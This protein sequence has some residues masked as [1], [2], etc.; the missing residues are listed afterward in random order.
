MKQHKHLT[1]ILA[2]ALAG[3]VLGL[4]IGVFAIPARNSGGQSCE[5]AGEYLYSQLT[6]AHRNLSAYAEE[7]DLDA[8][9]Q[10]AAA[11][12]HAEG[13]CL[14]FGKDFSYL[15][16]SD[17]VQDP[18]WCVAMI[19][20]ASDEVDAMGAELLPMQEKS[21]KQLLAIFAP[22][23]ASG[24]V[25]FSTLFENTAQTDFRQVLYC[26]IQGELEE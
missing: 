18:L 26:P 8:L 5:A 10:A 9:H 4:L 6:A 12:H 15:S 14:G 19:A 22:E 1:G 13:V 7:R 16:K 3:L 24:T 23:E 11:L 17:E 20:Y 2:A 25:H 21:L